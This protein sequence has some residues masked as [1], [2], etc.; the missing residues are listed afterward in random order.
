M[1]VRAEVGVARAQLVEAGLLPDPTIRWEC[2]NVV[3]RLLTHP[4]AGADR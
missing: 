3:A 1:G 2:G 4:E